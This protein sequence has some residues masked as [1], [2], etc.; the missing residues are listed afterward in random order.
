M[1]LFLFNKIKSIFG[2]KI[3][4]KPKMKHLERALDGQNQGWKYLLVFFISLII[5]QF[6]GSIPLVIVIAINANKNGGMPV[7]PENI[8]DFS[9]YGIDPNFGLVLMVIPFLVSLIIAILLIKAFHKRDYMAVIN[10]GSPFRFNRF[11]VAFVL[12]A[13]ISVV[14]LFADIALNPDNF[15]FRINLASFIPLV[16]I[17]VLLIPFQ[18]ATEEFLFRG[19]LAQGVA[20]WTKRRLLVILIP[21]LLFALM[22]GMNPEV[23][24]F[25][26]WSAM[27]MYFMFGLVFA[28]I[29]TLDDGIELAIGLHAA[30][31]VFSSIFITTKSSVLQTPAMFFQKEVDPFRDTLILLLASIICI[32]FLAYKYKW[33]FKFL[34]TSIG[35]F[36]IS[37]NEIV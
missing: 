5:G 33:D 35:I 34:T 29:S 30:N 20:A 3:N 16:L 37:K 6:I 21:S 36:P 7:K 1:N 10:G 25:G 11:F 28:I 17:S 14:F 23:D 9:A 19:Y 18:A 13:I 4:N 24:D 26:F 27:P 12:W 2:H 31:N 32:V 15:E 22:H 8:A